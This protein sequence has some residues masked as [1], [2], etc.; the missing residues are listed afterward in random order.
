MASIAAIGEVMVELRPHAAAED[1]A[2]RLMALSYAGDTYNTAIYMARCGAKTRYVTVL[3]DDRFSDDIFSVLA[4]ENI[5]SDLIR[6]KNGRMP[7]LYT[8]ENDPDGERHFSYWRK[9]APARELFTPGNETEVLYQQLMHCEY[10]YFSGITLAIISQEARQ[11]LLTFLKK[12]REQGGVVAFDSNYR[13][14]LWGSV[15]EARA[16]SLAFLALSDIAL[17]TFDDE[18]LLWGDNNADECIKRYHKM[19]I[20]ELVIKR[21]AQDVLIVTGQVIETISVPR[22]QNVVDT[23]GAGDTFNAGYL[24]QRLAGWA[25]IAAAKEGIRCAGIVI[26]HPGGVIASSIFKQEYGEK[27]DILK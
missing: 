18:A 1:N 16:S 13:P 19:G 23:T 24:A 12:Y 14:A 17:L 21:G 10:L 11:S 4:Q 20:G 22:V 2:Q 7:G 25:P 6:R 8:I 27:P 5:D 9:E 3:A 26:R 15:D